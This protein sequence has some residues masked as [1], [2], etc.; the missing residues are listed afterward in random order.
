MRIGDPHIVTELKPGQTAICPGCA[1]VKEDPC[2]GH[3]EMHGT[4]ITVHCT[5]YKEYKPDSPPL[6]ELVKPPFHYDASSLHVIDDNKKVMFQLK[7]GYPY[8]KYEDGRSKAV[9]FLKFI[10]SAMNEKYRNA[11]S[12]EIN[13]TTCPQYATCSK[14]KNDKCFENFGWNSDDL[15]CMIWGPNNCQHKQTSS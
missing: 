15:T 2:G 12:L 4:D 6:E 14:E 7:Y 1:R 5:W 8:S 11:K 3:P 13:D 10:V 9:A